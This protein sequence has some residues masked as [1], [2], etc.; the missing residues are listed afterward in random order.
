MTCEAELDLAPEQCSDARDD[1]CHDR[2]RWRKTLPM[3]S[4]NRG[5]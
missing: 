2:R 4:Q 1:L 3:A 5:R